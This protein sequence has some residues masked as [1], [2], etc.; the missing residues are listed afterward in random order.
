MTPNEAVAL[1]R[2][3][4]IVARDLPDYRWKLSQRNFNQDANTAYECSLVV[5]FAG[6]A[7]KVHTGQ[8]PT[9]AA[10][11]HAAV[12]KAQVLPFNPAPPEPA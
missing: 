9:P 1:G 3:L 7:R 11:V 2:A 12:A 6:N 8:G 10:A 5:G 4:I